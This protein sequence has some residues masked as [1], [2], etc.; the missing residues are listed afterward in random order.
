MQ[1]GAGR[2]QGAWLAVDTAIRVADH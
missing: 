2:A 1:A